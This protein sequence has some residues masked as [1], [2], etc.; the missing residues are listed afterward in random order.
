M[1][2]TKKNNLTSKKRLGLDL[3]TSS[4]GWCLLDCNEK[5]DTYNVID[6]GVRLWTS[7]MSKADR[8]AYRLARRQRRYRK[9][10]FKQLNEALNKILPPQP[11]LER[12]CMHPFNL[13]KKALDSS[14]EPKELRAILFHIAKNR[15]FR[16][17][18]E[19]EERQEKEHK[20]FK[21]VISQTEQGVKEQAR[22]YGEW[23]FK[24]GRIKLRRRGKD[25]P[26]HYPT[27]TLIEDEFDKIRVAQEPHFP[28]LDWDRIKTAI[29][30]QR[31]SLPPIVGKCSVYP[32]E[33][34]M[35]KSDPLAL[36][37]VM[38]HTLNNITLQSLQDGVKRKLT[39]Q[40]IHQAQ[41]IC[42]SQKTTQYKKLLKQLNLIQEYEIVYTNKD[43]EKPQ[44]PGLPVEPRGHLHL[45]RKAVEEILKQFWDGEETIGAIQN[46][47]S[48]AETERQEAQEY[49]EYYGKS[50]KNVPNF[51]VTPAC[52]CKN[53][54]SC[55]HSISL[56]ERQYGRTP[57]GVHHVAYNQLRALVNALIHRYGPIDEIT[58]ELIRA[59]WDPPKNQK[60]R[61][62]NKERNDEVKKRLEAAS[63]SLNRENMTRG[64]L[65]LEMEKDKNCNPCC[66][67]CGESF[68]WESIFA[69]EVQIEHV[70]PRSQTKSNDFRYLALSCL[71]CNEKKANRAPFE[72][73]GSHQGY[74]QMKWRMPQSKQWMFQSDALERFKELTDGFLPSSLAN[75]SN[76]AKHAQDYLQPITKKI[77]AS[78]GGLTDDLRRHLQLTNHKKR[79]KDSKHHALDAFLIALICPPLLQKLSRCEYD[80][81]NEKF[82]QPLF[83]NEGALAEQVI[84]AL[85]HITVSHKVDHALHGA[86]LKATAFG[87]YPNN[88]E[89]KYK[90]RSPSAKKRKKRDTRSAD[91]ANMEE[92]GI[93]S[94]ISAKGA[95]LGITAYESAEYAYAD[96][97][98][99]LDDTKKAIFTFTTLRKALDK[100]RT[101]KEKS[102]CQ[103][104]DNE[105]RYSKG[106]W[107]KVMRLR[108]GD[109]L[110]DGSTGKIFRIQ[111]F[112][113]SGDRIFLECPNAV[114]PEK[115]PDCISRNAPA[116]IKQKWHLV[117]VDILGQVQARLPK[118]A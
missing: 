51:Y 115:S 92:I 24:T 60:I 68:G 27:R 106:R 5:H 117:H 82:K 69:P 118:Q 88:L 111:M 41:K 101:G 59:E 105:G 43:K 102:F 55:P 25:K 13:R 7:K 85:K 14:L 33:I 93:S 10:R 8:R 73:F 116:F 54:D 58:V 9:C 35:S 79:S 21:K 67:F 84:A 38:L 96:L 22:T 15:G 81:A 26:D 3:G 16:R 72:A 28:D 57:N 17:S 89:E 2:N 48:D 83:A 45:S 34:R 46:R 11:K 30:F 112:A 56:E 50:M 53:P 75:T 39:R 64:K 104:L 47:L 19:D 23:L 31:D 107:H 32:N 114:N 61:N 109:Y 113:P 4:I 100:I 110:R 40:E 52:C 37:F 95:A 44:V 86:I 90:A 29:F 91:S 49:L 80:W 1:P 66:P 99:N 12:V 18:E 97:W 77:W 62:Q 108:K 98:Q 6:L 103:P 87:V 78:R 94:G 36:T 70:L 74:D 20:G 65:F 63:R 76:I 71:V 42:E